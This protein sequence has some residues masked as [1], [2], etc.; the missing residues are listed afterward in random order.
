MNQIVRTPSVLTQFRFNSSYP[1]IARGAL[2][3]IGASLNFSIV[4]L[5]VQ[6]LRRLRFGENLPETDEHYGHTLDQRNELDHQVE[7]D[8]V[9]TALREEQGFALQLKPLDLAARLNL[10][11]NSCANE[12]DNH[13]GQRRNPLTGGLFKNPWDLVSPIS[14][15]LDWMLKQEVRI[16]EAIVKDAVKVLKID[17][18]SIRAQL[19]RRH[20]SQQRFVKENA[21]EIF[22][23][24]DNLVYKGEDGHAFGI[25]DDETVEARLPSINRARLFIGAD[26][27][28]LG[29]RQRYVGTY[30]NGDPNARG[31]IEM[32]DKEREQLHAKF[33]VLVNL[34]GIKDEIADAVDN[35][36]KYPVLAALF[37][38]IDVA[39]AA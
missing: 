15:S 1:F 3:G 37:P 13:A 6:H 32:I 35:G 18:Q 8:A 17:E 33:N 9:E 20:Q 2:R 10:I 16:N 27:G 23:I 30:M 5:V 25:D 29:Q 21:A 12:L 4:A 22:T 31:N 38:K 14:E 34:P 7:G 19:L 28:L 26:K 24:I 36:A 39:K 11:R